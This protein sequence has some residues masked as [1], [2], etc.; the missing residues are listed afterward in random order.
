MEEDFTKASTVKAVIDSLKRPVDVF[1]YSSPCAGGSTSGLPA[2]GGE[3]LSEKSELAQ[4]GVARF[5]GAPRL[6]VCPPS[7]A[8]P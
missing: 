3:V 6:E 4:R 7:P 5:Y 2:V 1:F 8:G